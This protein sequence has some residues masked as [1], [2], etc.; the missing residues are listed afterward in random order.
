MIVGAPAARRAMRAT[1]RHDFQIVTSLTRSHRRHHSRRRC[2]PI[3][4]VRS[5]ARMRAADLLE[6]VSI[7]TQPRLKRTRRAF[8]GMRQGSYRHGTRNDP[9]LLCRRAPPP[10]DVTT[11]PRSRVLACPA[12]RR[13]CIVLGTHARCGRGLAPRGPDYAADRRARLTLSRVLPPNPLHP[14]ADACRASTNASISSRSA[15]RRRRSIGCRAVARSTRAA[16]SPSTA[17]SPRCP[18]CARSRRRPRPATS[19][20]WNRPSCSSRRRRGRE[21]V[22]LVRRASRQDVRAAR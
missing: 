20:L 19:R 13:P 1:D 9:D 10:L 11:R 5:D 4:R 6:L 7:T 17:A 3:T 12:R 15:A 22:P 14:R 16:R 2:W 18:S 8:R 21:R